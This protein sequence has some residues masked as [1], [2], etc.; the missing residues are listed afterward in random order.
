MPEMHLR[1]PGFTYSPCRPCSKNKERIQKFKDT[2][3]SRYIYQKG[4][5]KPCFQDDMAYG[6]FRDLTRRTVSGKIL[7]GKAFNIAINPKYS[8][9]Q[10]ALASMVYKYCDKNCSSLADKSVGVVLLKMKYVKAA[11]FWLSL[12]S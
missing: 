11:S 1:Q 3:D 5:H 6:D 8:G 7:S 12:H 9:H 4:L 10:R 2:W